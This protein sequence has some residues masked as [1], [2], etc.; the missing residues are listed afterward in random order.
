MFT[1]SD[2]VLDAGHVCLE[3]DGLHPLLSPLL[4]LLNLVAC[5]CIE[6]RDTFVFE[7]TDELPQDGLV[8][9]ERHVCNVAVFVFQVAVHR[10]SGW[11]GV[12]DVSYLIG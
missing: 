12:H 6:V 8:V 1:E 4:E 5:E 7:P 2:E 3:S 10:F 9:R 11:C